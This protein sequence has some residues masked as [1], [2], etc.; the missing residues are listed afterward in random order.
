MRRAMT[1]LALLVVGALGA[2]WLSGGMAQVAAWAMEA[3]RGFQNQMA[4]GL[5]D[6]RA[7]QPGAL[8]AFWGLCFAYGFVHAV[9]PGHGKFL[10]GA[11]GAGVDVP[12][13]RLVGVGLAASLA[14]GLSAIA[15]VYA[16]VLVFDA[17]R[18][19]LQLT[20]DVWLERASLIAIALIGLWLMSR[21]LRRAIA[22][23]L[24]PPALAT[25]GGQGTCS[26]C[27]HRHGPELHEVRALSGWRD[28]LVLIGAI[29]IRPCT[30]AL[31]VLI[32]TWR[33]GLIWQGI[34]AVM[35]MAL[36]TAAVTMA[37]AA[38]AVMAREGATA[39]LSQLDRAR[40]LMPMIEGLAGLLIMLLALNMLKMS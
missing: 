29:A 9:G 11:Y 27:G 18:E 39:R 13:A 7:G 38:T 3:Q 19:A 30:G 5:R 25:A 14:Q 26:E 4:Q 35:V 20:G 24:A 2:L 21:A 23:S 32:L 36:G 1:L 15:L 40:M 8:A 31:F 10:I 34:V 16:G 28:T 12:V 17:S 33:M 6:L 22:Q 37:V